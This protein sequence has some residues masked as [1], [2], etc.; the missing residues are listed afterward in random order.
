MVQRTRPD[1]FAHATAASTG[2]GSAFPAGSTPAVGVPA[3]VTLARLLGR[4]A[5]REAMQAAAAPC[6]SLAP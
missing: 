5:A 4:Q 1:P 2:A 6:P 3:L